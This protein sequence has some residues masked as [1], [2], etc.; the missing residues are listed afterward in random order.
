[1]KKDKIFHY[2]PIFLLSLL[3]VGI[4]LN[5]L[6]NSFIFDDISSIVE[7][8]YIRNLKD[9]SFFLKGLEVR[10]ESFRALPTLSFAIN[11]HLHKLNVFGYHLVNLALHLLSG[12]L[13]YFISRHLF[14]LESQDNKP[15][16]DDPGNDHQKINLLSLLAAAIF[17]SH[18]I[19]ANTVTYVVG[20]NEGMASFFYLL[21]LFFFIKMSL[22]RGGIKGL[23]LLG[24]GMTFFFAI[25]SKEI[26]FTL[27]AILILFDLM[28]ICKNWKVIKTRLKFYIGFGAPFIL[29]ILFFVKGGVIKLL[30]VYPGRW[31][32]WENLLTQFNVIIQY[33]KLLF[34]PLPGWLNIDH[35]FQLSKS[36]FEYP[37]WI[38]L[39]IILFLF[40]LAVF[41][42]KK[43]RLISFCIFFFFIV[44]APSSSVIP[45]WD[46]MV[47]YRLYLPIF[48]FCLILTKGLNS[49]YQLLARYYSYKLSRG[50]LL[51]ISVII[52][53]S[54]SAITIDRNKIFKDE[55]ILW[56]DAAKKSPNKTRPKENLITAYHR[57]GLNDQA[58]ALSLEVLNKNPRDHEIYNKLGISYMSLGEYNKAIEYLK[59]SIQIENNNPEALNNLGVIYLEKKDFPQAI[60]AFKQAISQKPNYSEAHNNLAKALAMSGQLDDA[61]IVESKAIRMDPDI[62]EYRFNLA[63][64]Y[65]NKG[66][67]NE[68][69]REYKE[70]LKLNPKFFEAH[71]HLGMI[72]TKIGRPNEAIIEFQEAIKI[73]PKSG[74]IY[75]MLGV[76]FLKI[77]NREKA[78]SNLEMAL[79]YATN[80][81]DKNAI[82]SAL[83]QLRP[84]S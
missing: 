8:P 29:Y 76:N 72:Y 9:I 66:L 50:V 27:P 45:I 42:I 17:I 58:I 73:N 31:T 40:I 52:L 5:S 1:M 33:F 10:K 55:L 49:F 62:A 70:G 24:T 30:F 22:S 53:S 35:D 6:N 65:E 18:P 39:S 25:L 59:T 43:N 26:A 37:T 2:I 48:A 77:K 61:I 28:F 69:V 32:P 81:N 79:Q 68:A 82:Q 14:L 51:G 67:I 74:K 36:L 23:Y 80:E 19:Q 56:S 12:L 78:I 44:L 34:L 63:K 47:E 54:Y 16:A 15:L 60:T 11:Y 21:G 13:V 83:N 3:A 7:N 75:F 57:H 46:L 41:L 64:L 38:S 71:Y 84:A 20:R 4:Y